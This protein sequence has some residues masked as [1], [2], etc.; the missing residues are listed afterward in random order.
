MAN[1][2]KTFN[3]RNGVQVDD[4]NLIVNPNGLVGLG[5]TVPTEIL[6]VRGTAKVVGLLTTKD[7]FSENIQVTGITTLRR[8][9]IGITSI[10][11]SG[12]ITAVSGIVTYYGDG[13]FLQGL[14]TSQWI[15]IDIGLGYTSIYASGFVGVTTNSPFY[16]FQ[17]GGTDK[18]RIF[19]NVGARGVGID[20]TG[21]IYSTGIV[22]AQSY[23]GIGIGLTELNASNI[24]SGTL[25]NDRLP[26]N[27]NIS[28]ILTASSVVSTNVNINLGGINV[29]GIVTSSGGF[30]GNVTGNVLGDLT[31]TATTARFLTGVPNIVV[32]IV[33]SRETISQISSTGIS[34]VTNR[35]YVGNSIGVNTSSPSTNLQ[36]VSPTSGGIQV[37]SVDESF[38]VV[39]KSTTRNARNA[40]IRVGN[41]VDT[42]SGEKSLDIV[43]YQNGNINQYLHLGSPGLGTGN[44]NWIYGQDQ[45]SRMTLTWDGRLGVGRTNPIHEFDVVGTSTIT[46]DL[47]VGDDIFVRGDSTLYGDVNV[48]GN[49]VTSNIQVTGGI[50]ANLNNTS[51]IS[52]FYQINVTNNAKL[53]NIA[54]GTDTT[55]YPVQIG[56]DETNTVIAISDANFIGIGTTVAYNEVQINAFDATTIIRA[57]GVGTTRPRSAVDFADAGRGYFL[58]SKRFLIPPRVT[59]AERNSLDTTSVNAAGALVYNSQAN[60]H[61]AWNGSVWVDITGAGGGGSVSYAENAGKAFYSTVAGFATDSANV[62]GGIVTCTS[63]NVFPGTG[64]GIS[65]FS[66]ITTVTGPTLFSKQLNVSGLS[67]F[68]NTLRVGTGVTVNA[69]IVTATGGFHSGIGTAVQITTVGNRIVFTVP[70]VGT[71]SLTLF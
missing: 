47:Y 63:I 24:A 26:S 50:N 19:G 56:A 67:T 43:N 7:I 20:S 22:T 35:L 8:A 49:F 57:V 33:T 30:V 53:A 23:N 70:G 36:I 34:T 14:P 11:S 48:S 37:T 68:H 16:P 21:N 9:Q 5:T 65:T 18:T 45:L 27:I 66:G 42:F 15:D 28:G 1:I 46:Q 55:P 51:G 61:Q 44:F 71:T 3:F 52:T 64:G 62:I 59:T 13:R 25:N 41:L 29:I 10:T 4:D 12:I 54:I 2:R 32:G 6:D 40:E 38:I 69:G 58:D 39:G 60:V 31:G 17:V